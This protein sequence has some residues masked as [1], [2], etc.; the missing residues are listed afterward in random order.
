MTVHTVE[1]TTKTVRSGFLDPKAP[2]VAKIEPG[3]VVSYPNTWFHWGNEAKFGMS[4]ADRE[5]LRHRYPNGPYSML[6]PVEVRGAEPGDV[7]ECE[8]LSLR[9][10][11]W[12]SNSSRSV[13]VPCR[14]ISKS[15]T[16]TISGST[17]PVRARST[18][19][20]SRFGLPR[21]W[22]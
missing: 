9:T 19:R 16:C 15:R 8:L 22:A 10:H 12:G 2:A 11:D 17:K 3:D 21:S 14:R 4:F 5:P 13:S 18:S 20:A 6:G 7:I 1:S